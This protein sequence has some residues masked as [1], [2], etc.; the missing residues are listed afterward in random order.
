MARSVVAITGA[1]SGIGEI[2]ARKLAPEH[3]LILIARRR[4]RLESIA[5]E[6]EKS[7]GCRSQVV[8]ADLSSDEGLET[9]ANV[10]TGERDLVLLVNNAGFGSK[11]YFWEKAYDAEEKMYR[12]HVMATLRLTH[13][14][15]QNMVGQ[16]R[17]AIINVASV[18]AF[19]RNAGSV[20]YGATKTWMTV[21]TEGLY[22]ELKSIG[23]NVTVQALCPGFTYSEFHDVMGVDRLRMAPRPFW[24]R[25]EDVV[26]ASLAG[27]ARR[28][29]IVV[30]GWRYRVLTAFLSALPTSLRI[31]VE[32]LSSRARSKRLTPGGGRTELGP[33]QSGEGT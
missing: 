12:V 16:D 25:A 19:V 9:A 21:F 6:L 27:L 20:S 23:S 32:G 33:P 28:Q 17:G 5:A 31:R 22:L 7:Y 11:G 2:F 4:D 1:S 10:I 24:M 29:L 15:L 13:A 30:P 18:A 3:N 26:D 14:A 8:E